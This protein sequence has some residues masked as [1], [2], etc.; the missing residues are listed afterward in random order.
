MTSYFENIRTWVPQGSTL[1]P[2]LFIIYIND[3]VSASTCFKIITYTDPTTP[4]RSFT[5]DDFKNI[6][7]LNHTSHSEFTKNKHMAQR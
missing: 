1:G 7:N 6:D 4:S 2:F 3:I 5:I